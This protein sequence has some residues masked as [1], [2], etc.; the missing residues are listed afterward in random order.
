MISVPISLAS[1]TISENN[2]DGTTY[3]YSINQL[4][5]QRAEH[6]LIYQ[7]MYITDYISLTQGILVLC[8]QKPLLKSFPS[9]FLIFIT[10][11]NTSFVMYC[12]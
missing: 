3:S 6:V 5:E 8:L 11:I 2:S 4:N 10:Y 7:A 12:L 1:F 9:Y